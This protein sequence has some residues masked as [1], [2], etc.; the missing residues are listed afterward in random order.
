MVFAYSP[1]AGLEMFKLRNESK[2]L[3][4]HLSRD[5]QRAVHF[6]PHAVSKAK[7]QITPFGQIKAEEELEWMLRCNYLSKPI[8]QLQYQP[9]SKELGSHWG[10]NSEET[11]MGI[12]GK[13]D[14]KKIMNFRINVEPK[15]EVQA[16]THFQ[17]C[18]CFLH[19]QCCGLAH[20]VQEWMTASSKLSSALSEG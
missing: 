5:S 19:A 9:V 12:C 20:T 15:A 14:V 4:L 2:M 7:C 17:C 10:S 18:S 1:P 3:V 8:T 16:H 11:N 13:C 6:L